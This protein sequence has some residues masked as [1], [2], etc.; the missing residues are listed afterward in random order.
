MT[1]LRQRFG[2]LTAP[3]STVVRAGPIHLGKTD[4][5]LIP[6]VR[7]LGACE[8]AGIA[9]LHGPPSIREWIAREQRP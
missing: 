4:D 2:W 5:D 6:A 8:A 9:V 7:F 1:P 3:R